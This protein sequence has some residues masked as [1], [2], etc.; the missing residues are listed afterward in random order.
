MILLLG[1]F[2][3]IVGAIQSFPELYGIVFASIGMVL[4][5]IIAILY[6]G[7]EAILVE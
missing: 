1:Q 3:L 4:I 5:L 7:F 2:S 6:Q